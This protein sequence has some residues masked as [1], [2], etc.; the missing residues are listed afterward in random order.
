MTI[1]LTAERR[2]LACDLLENLG[3]AVG[4][5]DIDECDVSDVESALDAYAALVCAE[6]DAEFNRWKVAL[7]DRIIAQDAEI[8]RLREAREDMLYQFAGD[9]TRD[10]HPV[11][12]TDGLSALEGAFAA[13]GWDDPY[14]P[15]NVEQIQCQHPGCPQRSTCGTPTPEG[16]KR[17]CGDHYRA[18]HAALS[19]GAH[20]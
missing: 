13:L 18:F 16:Y 9:S 17:F 6:K 2:R 12:C 5:L 11:F 14:T 15:P 7:G 4:R 8:E 20:E 1:D 3:L 19:G 10:G